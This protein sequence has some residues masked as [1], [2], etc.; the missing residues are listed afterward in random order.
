MCISYFFTVTFIIEGDN[1]LGVKHEQYM[2]WFQVS[3]FFIFDY[4]ALARVKCIDDIIG[5]RIETFKGQCMWLFLGVN[6]PWE[7]CRYI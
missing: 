7:P 4:L 2:F 3:Q 6:Q 1:I 5:I